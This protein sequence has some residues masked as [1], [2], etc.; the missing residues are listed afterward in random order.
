[1]NDLIL[2]SDRIF[3][4]DGSG[5]FSGAIAINKGYITE[6]MHNKPS[7]GIDFGRRLIIPGFCDSHIHGFLGGLQ[8]QA[9]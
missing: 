5:V 4:A 7:E 8:M 3:S 6:V 2:K 9:P 1:M